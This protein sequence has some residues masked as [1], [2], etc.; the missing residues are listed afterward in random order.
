ML[1]YNVMMILDNKKQVQVYANDMIPKTAPKEYWLAQP[2]LYE[3]KVV[4]IKD[5]CTDHYVYVELEEVIP[6]SLLQ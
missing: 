6:E 5:R 1:F 3:R 2:A 4:K